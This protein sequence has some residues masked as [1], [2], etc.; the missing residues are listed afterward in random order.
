MSLL[1]V[2]QAGGSQSHLCTGEPNAQC[3][4]HWTKVPLKCTLSP[5]CLTRCLNCLARWLKL[6]TR[7]ALDITFLFQLSLT[8]VHSVCRLSSNLFQ[9]EFLRCGPLPTSRD[10]KGS[11]FGQ[12]LCN[13]AVVHPSQSNRVSVSLSVVC[14]FTSLS[15]LMLKPSLLSNRL[16]QV[17]Q[18]SCCILVFS[19]VGCS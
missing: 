4:F 7:Q 9:Q 3:T 6:R 5:S 2:S 14:C 16:T 18:P 1:G 12:F 19:Q 13:C 17:C 10:G 15:K 11:Y 8:L